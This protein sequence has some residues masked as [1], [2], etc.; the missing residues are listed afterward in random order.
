MFHQ[1][2]QGLKPIAVLSIFLVSISS[3]AKL[4]KNAYISFEMDDG[5]SCTL[6]QTE[7]VCRATDP[8]TA[9]EAMII[10]TAK[11]KGPT[12]SLPLY[13]NHMNNPISV[14]SKVSGPMTSV[15]KYKVQQNKINDHIWLDALHQDS[16]VKHY[17]TRYLATL[18]GNIAVLVTFSAH[19]K[20]Y[21]KHSEHFNRAI[22]TIRLADET[23]NLIADSRGMGESYGQNSSSGSIFEIL[24]SENENAGG[25]KSIW[26]NNMIL[27]VAFLVLAAL[28][29]VVFR[30]LKKRR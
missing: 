23:N 18:K 7:W 27:G 10:L 30:I 15:L 24:Q 11:E 13:E 26:Q 19:N 20:H 3:Q 16:E 4:F 8:N 29:F 25:K 22:Q 1:W 2:F 21:S 14:V 9:K 12:D 28:I 17:F 6:E 5:W